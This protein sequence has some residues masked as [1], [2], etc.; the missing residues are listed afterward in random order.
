MLSKQDESCNI[1][2]RQFKDSYALGIE[3]QKLAT[4][5][6]VGK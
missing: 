6:Y 2:G 5:L 1:G 4:D 3:V